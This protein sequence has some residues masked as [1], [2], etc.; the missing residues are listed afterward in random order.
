M[1]Y[2]GMGQYDMVNLLRVKTQVAVRGISLHPFPLKH[3]AIEQDFFPVIQ[4]DQMFTSGY[5]PG[6]TNKFDLHRLCIYVF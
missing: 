6:C 4:C 5:F 2:V 1:V 3:T